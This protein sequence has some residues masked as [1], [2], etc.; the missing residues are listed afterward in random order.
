MI[1]WPNFY[2]VLYFRTKP[3]AVDEDGESNIFFFCK[4]VLKW[5]EFV[6]SIIFGYSKETTLKFSVTNLKKNQIH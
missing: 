1:Y 4:I 6:R 2:T 3:K 5:Q